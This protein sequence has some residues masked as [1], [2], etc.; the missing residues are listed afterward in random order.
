MKGTLVVQLCGPPRWLTVCVLQAF[1]ARLT[2]CWLSQW[3]SP[4]LTFSRLWVPSPTPQGRTT[5][6]MF[7]LLINVNGDLK[8]V[9]IIM[10]FFL[11]LPVLSV[12]V[13]WGVYL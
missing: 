11:F 8:S 1:A 10:D 5:V 9:P 6:Y 2:V 12:F 13:F 7:M 3:A 4:S